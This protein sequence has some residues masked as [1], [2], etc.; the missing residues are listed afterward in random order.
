MQHVPT[1]PGAAAS[2]HT[3]ARVAYSPAEF[4]ALLGLSRS[5]LYLALAEKDPAK[6]IASTRIGSR[7]LIP[8]TELDRLLKAAA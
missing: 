7:R 2:G 8:A 5:T 1:K 6:R 3:G 4:A